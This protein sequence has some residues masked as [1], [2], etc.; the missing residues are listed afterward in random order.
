[1][2]ENSRMTSTLQIGTTTL[3]ALAAGVMLYV[4][5]TAQVERSVNFI[6]QTGVS[7]GATIQ[8]NSITRWQQY[9]VTC[10]ATGGTTG[11]YSTCAA[12]LPFTST[13]GL[14]G[15]TL[16]CGNVATQLTGDVSFK[17]SLHSAT[18]T[19]LTN[20][21]NIVAGTGSYEGSWFATEQAW[22][23]ADILTFSTTTTPSGTLNTTRYDCQMWATVS[24]KYGS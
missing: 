17:K 2:P 10:T 13:G 21:N 7:T 20:L 14:L 6:P 19:V 5:G 3:A 15:V 12:N 8:V 16:E 1:M 23:P 18:G 9:P 24:D 11:L 22:N 4:A